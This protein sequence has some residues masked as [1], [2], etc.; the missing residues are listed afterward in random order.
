MNTWKSASQLGNETI[1]QMIKILLDLGANVN[2]TCDDYFF[3]KGL[4]TFSVAC[5]VASADV[6]K[7]MI[8][9]GAD[10]NKKNKKG[11]TPVCFAFRS[12]E[13]DKID[14]FFE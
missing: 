11:R 10:F 13:E 6:V 7:I 1:E 12:G 9:H 14:F 5:R 2:R 4:S 3:Y 8:D